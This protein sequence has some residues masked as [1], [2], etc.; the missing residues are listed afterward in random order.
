LKNVNWKKSGPGRFLFLI[1]ISSTKEKVMKI[2]YKKI[3]LVSI[4]HRYFFYTQK[5]K[6]TCLGN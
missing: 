1:G 5:E 6:V 3:A 4:P 2:N